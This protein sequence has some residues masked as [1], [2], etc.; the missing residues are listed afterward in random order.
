MSKKEEWTGERLETFIFS[1]LTIEH[2]HRY[3]LAIELAT[4]KNVLDIACGE[5]YGTNLLASKATHVSGMDIDKATIEKAKAKYDKKN[6]SFTE[7]RV[8]KI[9][10]NDNEFD[11]VASFETL[12]HLSDQASMLKE[13]KRVMKQGGLLIISTP[14][15]KTYADQRGYKNPFHAKELYYDEFVALVKSVFN[16]VRVYNQQ[17]TH[18]SLIHSVVAT[19]LDIYDGD[20]D[21]IEKNK[22]AQPFYHIALASDAELPALPNSLFNGNSIVEHMLTE[23][24]KMLKTTFTYKLGHFILF[25][26]KLIKKLINK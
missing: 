8:E 24:G 13:I 3:A 22:P 25:P 20:F 18:S 5:G 12:E 26:F 17:I 4:G 6:I 21:K 11:L 9:S 10:A 19:G 7:S 15:K 1:E 14:D 16:H 2:L 23:K